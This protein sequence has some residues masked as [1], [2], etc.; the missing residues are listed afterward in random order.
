[1]RKITLAAVALLNVIGRPLPALARGGHFGGFG[2]NGSFGVPFHGFHPM[3]FGM[4]PRFWGF[5]YPY[6]HGFS[7]L[8]IGFIVLL[9]I[10]GLL[11]KRFFQRR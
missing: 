11:V 3:G 1:M 4:R 5:G 7:M 10:G 2:H 6:H 8:G 9:V